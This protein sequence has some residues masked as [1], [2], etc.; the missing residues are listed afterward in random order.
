MTRAALPFII[1]VGLLDTGANGLFA[2]ATTQGYLSLVAVL[3]SVYPVVTVMLAFVT[4]HERL[5]KHQ[6][7]GVVA[8]LAGVTLIAAG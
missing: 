3:G 8:A 5:A 4:L 2:L 1:A 7:A 6:L